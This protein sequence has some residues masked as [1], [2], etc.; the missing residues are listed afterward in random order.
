LPFS[1]R[2]R[3]VDHLQNAHDLA[4]AAVGCMGVLGRE[5]A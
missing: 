1:R 3:A 5:S 4:R 2:E